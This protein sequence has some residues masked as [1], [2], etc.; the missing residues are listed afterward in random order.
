MNTSAKKVFIF[1]RSEVDVVGRSNIAYLRSFGRSGLLK[2]LDASELSGRR[3]LCAYGMTRVD[4]EA[5]VKT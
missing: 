3:V 5:V 4:V 1:G 2:G